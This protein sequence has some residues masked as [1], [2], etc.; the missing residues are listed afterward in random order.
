MHYAVWPLQAMGH[1]AYHFVIL[2][3]KTRNLVEHLERIAA[4]LIDENW[5]APEQRTEAASALNKYVRLA[6]EWLSKETLE[7]L[8]PF[9][10]KD[11]DA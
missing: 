7:A 3:R 5:P 4:V 9:R 6:D 11:A 2:Q 10:E 1:V 8:K